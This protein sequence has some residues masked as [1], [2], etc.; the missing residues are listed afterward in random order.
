M[1]A[2]LG[3]AADTEPAATFVEDLD[4]L[5]REVVDDLYLRTLRAAGRRRA[6]R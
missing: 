2:G 1:L 5:V 4:D 6:G 3:I